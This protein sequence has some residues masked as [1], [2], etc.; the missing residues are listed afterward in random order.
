MT[1]LDLVQDYLL[2]D[3]DQGMRNLLTGFLNLAM[4]IEALQQ[5]GADPYERTESR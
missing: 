1:P 3:N 5:A 2:N 4:Q